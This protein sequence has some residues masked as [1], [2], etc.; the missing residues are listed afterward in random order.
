MAY[1][2]PKGVLTMIVP[3]DHVAIRVADMD[4]SI[5]FYTE[6]LGLRLMFKETSEEHRETFAFL[7]L[8]GGNLELLQSLDESLQPIPYAAP[9]PA[10][11]FT[12][13][14]ALGT[15]DLDEVLQKIAQQGISLVKGPLLIEGKVRWAYFPDPDGNILEFVQWL[16]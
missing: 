12:P 1:R 13:H 4:R 16:G 2:P 15:T 5:R 11:P 10:P 8:E 6:V 3:L 9:V 14:I 7:E